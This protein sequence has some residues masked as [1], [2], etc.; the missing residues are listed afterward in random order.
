MKSSK[1]FSNFILH[2]YPEVKES[3]MKS[4]GDMDLAYIVTDYFHYYFAD[5]I[6]SEKPEDQEKAKDIL[7]FIN[8]VMNGNEYDDGTKSM[9]YSEFIG[10][11]SPYILDE[12]GLADVFEHKKMRLA[13]E[14]FTGEALDWLR[15]FILN[16]NDRYLYKFPYIFDEDAEII[17][18]RLKKITEDNV[19]FDP[20]IPEY[21][22]RNQQA[23][24]KG[25]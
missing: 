17:I 25:E 4:P 24:N 8:Q 22:K 11:L 23:L 12:K 3:M 5:L 10:S 18:N 1:D 7:K 16:A 21:I 9:I 13:K 15:F 20:D 2:Q 6:M 14:I 19:Y